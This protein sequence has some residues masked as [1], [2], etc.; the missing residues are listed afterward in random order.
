MFLD[1]FNKSDRKPGRRNHCGFFVTLRTQGIIP[2][3]ILET[4]FGQNTICC[5]KIIHIYPNICDILRKILNIRDIDY[6]ATFILHT[7]SEDFMLSRVCDRCMF[8]F[9]TKVFKNLYCIIKFWGY[10][11]RVK[12]S[13]L[14]CHFILSDM[15][16]Q[17]Q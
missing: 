13:D 5:I 9:K 6:E 15:V 14:H 7:K 1:M 12:S 11:N 10:D 8:L 3:G 2:S 16:V 4:M 17:S